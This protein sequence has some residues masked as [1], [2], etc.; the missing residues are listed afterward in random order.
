MIFVHLLYC[1]DCSAYLIMTAS[2]DVFRLPRDEWT[3]V[4]HGNLLK[5]W[6]KFWK[7]RE[8]LTHQFGRRPDYR[9]QFYN[10]LRVAPFARDW[11]GAVQ[12]FPGGQREQPRPQPHATSRIGLRIVW[13]IRT[14]NLIW[15]LVSSYSTVCNP[16]FN[17]A[18]ESGLKAS[19]S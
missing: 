14:P 2:C 4:A 3:H 18:V 17:S 11:C 6:L 5:H 9:P 19:E 12:A 8:I 7:T 13:P 15:K 10:L 16:Q 1:F